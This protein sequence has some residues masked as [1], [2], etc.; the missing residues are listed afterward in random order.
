MKEANR[1]IIA[2]FTAQRKWNP[3]RK[4]HHFHQSQST[5]E[6]KQREPSGEA[7]KEGDRV[8]VTMGTDE[9]TDCEDVCFLANVCPL[10]TTRGLKPH[11][12]L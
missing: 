2:R 12:S 4:W 6:P 8:T 10:P 5:V 7:D 9:Q 1:K 3:N 11:I